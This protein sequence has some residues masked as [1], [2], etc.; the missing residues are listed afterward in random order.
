[1][2]KPGKRRNDSLDSGKLIE[3]TGVAARK[4]EKET[5]AADSGVKREKSGRKANFFNEQKRGCEKMK[6][7]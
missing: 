4:M 7:E 6:W 3:R 1:M 5:L 2:G